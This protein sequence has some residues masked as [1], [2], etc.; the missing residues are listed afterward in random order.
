MNVQLD[1]EVGVALGGPP[2]TEEHLVPHRMVGKLL[3]ILVLLYRL[4][5][6]VAMK[7]VSMT[8]LARAIMRNCGMV[9]YQREQKLH[10]HCSLY[11][12]LSRT[13]LRLLFRLSDSA[14]V[15]N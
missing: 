6:E 4:G 10:P 7:M 15:S 14:S 9:Y 13:Q 5:I 11:P 12:E 1:E 3:H 8:A 2:L